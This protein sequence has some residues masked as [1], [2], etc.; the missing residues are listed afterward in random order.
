M[1]KRYPQKTGKGESSQGTR[2]H[3]KAKAMCEFNMAKIENK[4]RGAGS[5][6]PNREF[7]GRALV[8]FLDSS[9]SLDTAQLCTRCSG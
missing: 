6:L 8:S 7:A 2:E 1:S 4:E 3:G 9:Q 5:T